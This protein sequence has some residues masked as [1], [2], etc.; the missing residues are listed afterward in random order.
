[1]R[2]AKIRRAKA[3]LILDPRDSAKEPGLIGYG[4]IDTEK[5]TFG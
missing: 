1:M 3:S 5:Q 4:F 2:A